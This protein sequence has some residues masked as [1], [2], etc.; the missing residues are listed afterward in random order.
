MTGPESFE[1][2]E[3]EWGGNENYAFDISGITVSA[4]VFDVGPPTQPFED[5]EEEW[6]GNENYAFDISGISIS[7]AVFDADPPNAVPGEAFEDL[8]ETDLTQWTVTVLS[9]V[10]NAV[11]TVTIDGEEMSH[12]AIPGPS[13]TTIRDG[14]IVAIAAG[15]KPVVTSAV[16][17]DAFTLARDPDIVEPPRTTAIGLAVGS[18]GGNNVISKSETDKLTNW[19]QTGQIGRE[20]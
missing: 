7:A 13:L 5:Y 6:G 12:T 15:S 16:G 10:S 18:D 9:A 2:F 17:A 4:A 1:D 20:P 11:Y 3:E 8:E 14:L 19:T